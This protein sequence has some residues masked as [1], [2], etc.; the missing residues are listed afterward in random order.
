MKT[1]K[2]NAHWTPVILSAVI[3]LAALLVKAPA[4][5]FVDGK[6]ARDAFDFMLEVSRGSIGGI[7]SVNKFGR[8]TNVDNG[9]VTDIW[10]GANATTDQDIWVAPTQAR[11]HQIT[12]ADAADDSASTGAR[13]L[14]V[15][16][17]TSWAAPGVSEDITMN[18]TDDVATVNS[19]VII[20][21]MQVLTKGSS[22]SNVGIITATADTDGTITA[23]INADAGQT[24]MGIYGI[25]STQ[26]AYMTKY[27]ASFNKSGGAT[28]AIDFSLL[29]NP[30]PDAELTNFIIKHTQGL[31]SSGDSLL[32]H[33]FQ[34]YFRIPG[35][36][37]IKLQ[38]V[39]SA[40]DLDLSG[41]FDL[42]LVD[43]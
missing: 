11:I 2:R 28:G 3:L 13:T 18:G 43:N 30:E 41:G 25:P 19:Y 37:I 35:P 14:R 21:R 26:T 24:Q 10:D 29:V 8:A 27:Y 15:S 42:I 7:S 34:P 17:L 23:Q 1:L 16:G 38:A 31:I 20:H 40:N 6:L 4:T 39:G 36:A 5:V 33:P 22:S 32:P 9:I 12:S